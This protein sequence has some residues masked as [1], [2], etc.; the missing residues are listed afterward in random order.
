MTTYFPIGLP[1]Q[2]DSGSGSDATSPPWTNSW[3]RSP[4]TIRAVPADATADR[5]AEAD[6][7]PPRPACH[8]TVV[9]GT[10]RMRRATP[11]GFTAPKPH[12]AHV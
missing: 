11:C 10:A 7:L 2:A 3:R 8:P 4:H 5:S 6:H 9:E 1:R 12:R